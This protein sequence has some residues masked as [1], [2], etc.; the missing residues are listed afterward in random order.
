MP[1]PEIEEFAKTLVQQVRDATIKSCDSLLRANAVHPVTNRWRE[2]ARDGNLESIATVLVP[3]IVDDTIFHLL[4]AI[5]EGH[6]KLSF[7]A[8]NGRKVEL[9]KDG[10]GE[11]AGWYMGRGGWRALY[12]EER[13]I[14]DFSDLK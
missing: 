5:D 2:T 8:A 9:P 13:L 14:D 3:D 6:L 1:N 7:T 12:S 10:L 11:L 4:L